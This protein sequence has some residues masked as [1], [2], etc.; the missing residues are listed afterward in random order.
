M[1]TAHS[2]GRSLV[3]SIGVDAYE[4]PDIP[5][6][7]WAAADARDFYS[8]VTNGRDPER[9]EARLLIND[10]ATLSDIR[11]ALGDWLAE[12]QPAD[13]VVIFFAG[14]GA[15]ELSTKSDQHA[16]TYLLPGAADFDALYSTSLALGAELPHILG[17]IRSENIIC[18]LD[19]CLSG[20]SRSTPPQGTRNRGVDGPGL[21]RAEA[22]R[23]HLLRSAV[24]LLDDKVEEIGEGLVVLSACG[25]NQSALESD[26]IGHGVFTQSLLEVAAEARRVGV[27]SLTVGHLYDE[28]MARVR[29]RSDFAQIPML[30]GRL[31]GQRFYV[32]S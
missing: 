26:E 9:V 30:D 10:L 21:R 7:R 1:V 3:V 25:P 29:E 23:G 5:S 32:G 20:A 17:R 31:S 24:P 16:D 18:I 15:R 11:H 22:H 27:R 6:L 14:H 28:T 2:P 13:N 12:A 8:V 19:C 4:H